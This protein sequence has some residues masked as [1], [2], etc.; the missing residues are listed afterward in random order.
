MYQKFLTIVSICAI[1][2][3]GFVTNAV[4]TSQ[5]G[6]V[7]YIIHG[8]AAQP[9]DHWFPWLEQSLIERGIEV[10]RLALPNPN[11][12]SVE[13]WLQHLDET[14]ARHDRETFFVAHSLG[15]IALLRHLSDRPDK[16]RVGGTLLVSGFSSRLPLLPQLDGFVQQRLQAE[17]IIAGVGHRVVITAEDDQ[18]VASQLSIELAKDIDATPLVLP[19]GGHF[20][21]SNGFDKFPLVL[22]QTIFMIE[23]TGRHLTDTKKQPSE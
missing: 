4:A 12:P 5:S 6:V 20:L 19:R 10:H 22:D 17:R 23:R 8:Y 21:A 14:V 18:I 9:S 16:S 7:V 13:E 2:C 3:M 1:G 11:N 15:C